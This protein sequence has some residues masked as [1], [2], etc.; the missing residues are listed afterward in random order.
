MV[1]DTAHRLAIEE[2]A[3]PADPYAQPGSTGS[4]TNCMVILAP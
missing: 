1:T 4:A 3:G 2:L